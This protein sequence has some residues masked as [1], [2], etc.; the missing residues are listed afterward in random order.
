MTFMTN[1]PQAQP[2]FN[3]AHN[4]SRFRVRSLK[5]ICLMIIMQ[6]RF[7]LGVP[8]TATRRNLNLSYKPYRRLMQQGHDFRATK[9]KTGFNFGSVLD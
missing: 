7:R 3:A 9:T 5:P 8:K 4:R 2:N 6:W 1:Y